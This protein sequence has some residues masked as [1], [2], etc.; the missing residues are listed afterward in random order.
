MSNNSESNNLERVLAT[1][2]SLVDCLDRMASEIETREISTENK[3][4]KLELASAIADLKNCSNKLQKGVFRLL[5]LGDVKR[6]KSTVINA[7]IGEDL[8]PRDV[9][10][11][12]AI[13]TVLRYGEEKK[14]TV[15]FNDR[16]PP[17]VLD[18]ET[19]KEQYSISPDE[20]KKLEDEAKL[21]FPQVKQAVIE[22]PLPLLKL[23]IEIV[24]SPGLN[25]TAAR[26]Q[27][28]LDYIYNCNAILFV[29]RAVQPFSLAERRYLNNYIKDRGL[30]VFFLINGWD[31]INNSLLEP[32]NE[33]E[34]NAAQEKSQAYFRSNLGEYLIEDVE[35]DRRVFPIS[36]LNTLRSYL[37]NSTVEIESTGF[38]RFTE[39]LN[40]FLRS[41]R[42]KTEFKQAK[43]I[44]QQAYNRLHE[45]V[46]RRVALLSESQA[47]IKQKLDTISPDF[48]RLQE[49]QAELQQE[50]QELGESQ[51]KTIADSFENY[52]LNLET[53][54]D[55]DFHKYQP[56][57]DSWGFLSASKRDNFNLAFKQG[58]DRYLNDKLL[59][60]EKKA[61][62]DLDK[63][64]AE[65]ITNLETYSKS[66]KEITDNINLKLIGY[67]TIYLEQKSPSDRELDWKNW[68]IGCIAL[69]SGNIGGLALASAGV[70]WKQVL[71][72]WVSVIGITRFIAIFTGVF[73]N[74]YSILL[75][76]LGLA[77]IQT[78]FARQEFIRLTKQEFVRY[79]PKIAQE[80]KEKV[81]ETVIDSFNKYAKEIDK[82]IDKDIK[83]RK[84]ELD[85]LVQQEEIS[86]R[87]RELEIANLQTFDNNVLTIYQEMI[88]K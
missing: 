76:S 16:T 2:N 49:L 15:Y 13:L 70:N 77:G 66:Y 42:V 53:T 74:P 11:C 22:Y 39:S 75:V 81:R 61:E 38:D 58:F 57:L 26:N 28:S 50:I 68:T 51:A 34:L 46:D 43:T 5:V 8:L 36:A 59:E 82:K 47:S 19:F 37:D 55:I 35:Y 9:N 30:D 41:E 44:A 83:A 45:A 21:A 17:E 18:F 6:G 80:Q 56:Q 54:F 72:N 62:A 88:S 65:L 33:Q 32:G 12:T 84:A 69:A 71:I 27:L 4:G 85:N 3:S 40:S 10:A 67:K 29:L 60:W 79:L 24:D 87:D 23:G 48:V 64:I 14:V 7:L 86:D 52:I 73:L 1:R 25:D 63:A 78:S 20:A 31:E